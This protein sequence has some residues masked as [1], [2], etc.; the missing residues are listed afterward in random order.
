VT[1]GITMQ[2]LNIDI[3]HLRHIRWVRDDNP[4]SA[5]NT[6]PGLTSNGKM[7]AQN[8]WIVS[9]TLRGQYASAM[10][11]AV[12]EQMWVDRNTCRYTDEN[13]TVQNPALQACAEGIS[14]VKAQAIAQQQGQKIYTIDQDNRATALAKLPVSGSVGAEIR[15]AVEAGKTV[16]FHEKQISAHGWT[17]YGFIIVDPETG[18]G[19]YLI[20]GKGNGGYL[21]NFNGTGAAFLLFIASLLAATSTV[22]VAGS[23]IFILGVLSFFLAFINILTLRLAAIE[24]DC[25]RDAATPFVIIEIFALALSFA[26]AAGAAIAAFLSFISGGAFVAAAKG[27]SF[28]RHRN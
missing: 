10:E 4:Q 22:G 25:G 5:V 21:D 9:N 15:S 8:R 13:G 6:Q 2:G 7:A 3:G 27:C 20:E 14:A 23:I 26:G 28:L 17:S 18:A 12:L 11:H 1:T 16:T 24:N 19:A